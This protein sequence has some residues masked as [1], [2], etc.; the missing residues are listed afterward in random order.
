MNHDKLPS[1]DGMNTFINIEDWKGCI[2]MRSIQRRFLIALLFCP[3]GCGSMQKDWEK[4]QKFDTPERYEEFRKD[5]PENPF[6]PQINEALER[7]AYQRAKT[8]DTEEAL[9]AFTT[10][11]PNS[12]FVPSCRNRIEELAFQ[13]CTS[14]ETVDCF[15]KFLQRFPRSLLAEKARDRLDPLLFHTAEQK[16]TEAAYRAY[17]EKFPN[18]THA[19]QAWEALVNIKIKTLGQRATIQDWEQLLSETP[20]AS[21]SAAVLKRRETQLITVIDQFVDLEEAVLRADGADLTKDWNRLLKVDAAFCNRST[22]FYELNG[23]LHD[24]FAEVA[25]AHSLAVAEDVRCPSSTLSYLPIRQTLPERVE[26]TFIRT[27]LDELTS[28]ASP[29]SLAETK[30]MVDRLAAHRQPAD[31]EQWSSEYW[32]ILGIAKMKHYFLQTKD[33]DHPEATLLAPHADSGERELLLAI[34]LDPNDSEPYMYLGLFYEVRGLMLAGRSGLPFHLASI[35]VKAAIGT[36]STDPI[37]AELLDNLPDE[38]LLCLKMAGVIWRENGQLE[39]L[40]RLNLVSD[41][42]QSLQDIVSH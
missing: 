22:V 4:T 14:L 1:K 21:T 28:E 30:R 29:S 3:L 11:Y 8:A 15:E 42:M 26:N 13:S 10:E 23:V 25:A 39:P 27:T 32:M 37:P 2:T 34:R 35:A 24:R 36:E 5:H 12:P 38:S 7:L 9:L 16:Q 20:A 17:L 40:F 6:E 31:F 19:T 18:G 41:V 33:S